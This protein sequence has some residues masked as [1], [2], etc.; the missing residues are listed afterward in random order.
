MFSKLLTVCF[1]LASLTSQTLSVNYLVSQFEDNSREDGVINHVTVHD[2]T[3]QV[4][5]G[6]VNG[7]YQLDEN[8]VLETE[9]STGPVDDHPDCI[10]ERECQSD[11]KMPTDSVSKALVVD[12]ASE[13]LITCSNVRQGHCERRHLRDLQ[14]TTSRGGFI[15][16]VNFDLISPVVMYIA[17]GMT[18]VNGAQSRV[19]YVASTQS[20]VES[21]FNELVPSIASRNLTTLEFL[22]DDGLQYSSVLRVK[23]KYRSTFRIQYKTGFYSEGFAYFLAVRPNEEG[24][25]RYNVSKIMRVC[26]N[27]N[28]YH[29]FVEFPLQCTHNGTQYNVLQDAYVTTPGSVLARSMGVSSDRDDVIFAVFTSNKS[30]GR[31]AWDASVGGDESPSPDSALC[32][33][34]LRE[35]RQMF[36]LAIQKCFDGV[37]TTGPDHFKPTSNCRRMV[38]PLLKKS[39][40]FAL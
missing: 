11:L 32:V 36:T 24:A 16:V 23:N 1:A 3:G 7:L 29:S 8:L 10:P 4:Y 15:P 26:T 14:E 25:N 27:D 19:L 31:S 30:Q 34:S 33:Y 37:G 38:R 12:Y 40:K 9:V 13:T 20:T 21:S 17:P 22:Y 5:I 18:N 2:N 35:V 39:P 28:K 6:A